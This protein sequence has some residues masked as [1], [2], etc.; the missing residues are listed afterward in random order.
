MGGNINIKR[1][2]CMVGFLSEGRGG[3]KGKGSGEGWS[4]VAISKT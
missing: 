4:M 3:E 2:R 1:E